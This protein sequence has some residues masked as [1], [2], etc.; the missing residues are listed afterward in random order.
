MIEDQNACRVFWDVFSQLPF[1]GILK[2]SSM[3]STSLALL[4]GPQSSISQAFYQAKFF[5]WLRF[6]L[7][8]PRTAFL[9][10]VHLF[11]PIFREVT[12]RSNRAANGFRRPSSVH[13]DKIT[14]STPVLKTD[15][16]LQTTASASRSNST[17]TGRNLPSAPSVLG[18]RNK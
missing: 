14:S 10:H 6:D 9:V 2:V 16:I 12:I 1:P 3:N 8:E 18:I 4:Q 13:P 15:V 11:A 17:K 5:P 7:I